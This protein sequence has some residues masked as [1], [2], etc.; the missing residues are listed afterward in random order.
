M[1]SE[2]SSDIPTM[3]H[4]LRHAGYRNIVSGKTHFIGADQSHGFDRRLTT[5]IYPSDFAWSID[6]R[7]HV[8]HRIGTSVKK[9]EVSGLCRTNNQILFDAEV[10]FRAIE[11]LRYEALEPQEK[12][13]F[14]HVSYT[15]PHE[16]YQSVPKFWDLYD[17]VEIRLPEQGE[18][19]EADRH[20][21]TRWLKIHH[22]IDQF[23]PSDHTIRAS[24]RAYYAMITQIDEYVGEI[25]AELAHLGLV[26]DTIV[27]FCSDHGDMVGERG[28][29]FKRNFYDKSVKV[30]LIVH[31]PKRYAPEG[32]GQGR[33]AGRSLPDGRGPGRRR[34][35]GG[36]VRQRPQ[37]QLQASDRRR[38]A[39]VEGPRGDGIFRPRGRGNPGS[40]SA[41]V[42]SSTFT[43]ATTPRCC[44]TWS[45]IRW[46]RGTWSGKRNTRRERRRC[47]AFCS[48][49]WI[50]KR[51]RRRRSRA[52]GLASSCTRCSRTA[53]A[54]IGIT[55][56]SSTPP[57]NM[58]VAPTSR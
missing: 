49:A 58:S 15:Q 53:T 5:D 55:S 27:L 4:F 6:W 7:P 33:L 43:P 47:M 9:L 57:S 41:R 36:A 48:P 45:R 30:P 31:N 46:K 12:P 50:S 28:M 8:E 39:R 1:G 17:D 11:F 44:S 22:G 37:P 40:R 19:A 26:E 54:T 25:M 10:Q 18:D 56:P 51:R 32:R 24:R 34:R 35:G 29:W 52:S 42:T 21:V 20:P 16:S 13:F 14:L 23:P 38:H 3:M 2:F